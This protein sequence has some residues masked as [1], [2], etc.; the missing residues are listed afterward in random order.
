MR[1]II[2]DTTVHISS[3]DSFK[4]LEN[5]NHRD[6]IDN[7]EHQTLRVHFTRRR[8]DDYIVVYRV[9]TENRHGRYKMF[10]CKGC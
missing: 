3:L 6:L 4:W 1:P 5:T 10:I 8:G 2:N 9:R 7:I